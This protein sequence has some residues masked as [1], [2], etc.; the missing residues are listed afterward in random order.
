MTARLKGCK[1]ESIDS[2]LSDFGETLRKRHKTH[3]KHGCST[4]DQ[5]IQQGTLEAKSTIL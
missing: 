3:G 5:V 1:V 4:P 2:G